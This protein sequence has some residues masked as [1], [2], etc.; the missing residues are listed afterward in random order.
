[1]VSSFTL[2]ME[3]VGAKYRSYTGILV[4]VPFAI[5]EALAGILAI[6]FKDWKIYQMATA[7][8]VLAVTMTTFFIPESPRWL[9]CNRKTAQ[10]RDTVDQISRWNKKPLS[11]KTKERFNATLARLEQ[12]E[13]ALALDEEEAG[14]AHE[15]GMTDV[16]KNETMR[17]SL[18][19][20]IV[21]WVVVTLGE[22]HCLCHHDDMIT[23]V[24]F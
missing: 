15:I 1:M 14:S 13:G 16:F 23:R 11:A 19:V 9:L 3:L 17:R 21:N 2:S 24:Y 12:E 7:A 10:L 8:V 20:M 6:F 18:L 4:N 5:G 22:S